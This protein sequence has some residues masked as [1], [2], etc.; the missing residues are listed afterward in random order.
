M[1]E[2]LSGGEN[3][4]F[5]LH[6]NKAFSKCKGRLSFFSPRVHSEIME[7]HGSL[8]L[9]NCKLKTNNL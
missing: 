3:D 9:L 7:A 5:L 1:A 6:T 2:V 4:Y 8:V